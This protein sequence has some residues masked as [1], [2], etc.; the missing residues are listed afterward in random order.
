[1]NDIA[2]GIGSQDKFNPQTKIKKILS[3]NEI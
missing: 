1:M 2:Y 3:W